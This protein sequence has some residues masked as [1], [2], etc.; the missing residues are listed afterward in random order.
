MPWPHR[1]PL[2]AQWGNALNYWGFDVFCE[3][4]SPSRNMNFVS[5][6]PPGAPAMHSA[7]KKNAALWCRA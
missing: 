7:T 3:D 1:R 4:I 2:F 6:W 5:I